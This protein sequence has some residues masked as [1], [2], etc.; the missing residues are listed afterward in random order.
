LRKIGRQPKLAR[1]GLRARL[2]LDQTSWSYRN[3]SNGLNKRQDGR[4]RD[5]HPQHVIAALAG[6]VETGKPVFGPGKQLR[7]VCA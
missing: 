2:R 5:Q 3:C 7:R 1:T 6:L 4:A